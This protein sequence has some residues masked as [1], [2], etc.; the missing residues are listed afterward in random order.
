MAAISFKAMGPGEGLRPQVEPQLVEYGE[1]KAIKDAGNLIPGQWYRIT[2]YVT[3]TMQ[4]DTQSAGHQFDILV[5]ATG[6]TTLCEKA[7]AVQHEG[8]EYFADS[9]L[10]AWE[11]R[12]TLENVQWSAVKGITVWEEDNWPLTSAGTVTI[13]NTEYMLWKAGQ[14]LYDDSGAEWFVSEDAEAGT[15]LYEYDPETG[16]IVE[17]GWSVEIVKSRSVDEDGVGTILWMKDEFGNE[18]PYDFKNIQFKRWAVTDSVSGRQGLN[19][20]YLGVYRFTPA[21]ITISDETDF[22]WAY[23][24]SSDAEGGD[25]ED[26]SLGGNHIIENVILSHPDGIIPDNV[27]F[28]SYNDGNSIGICS[29]HNS[30]AGNCRSN[31]IGSYFRMNVAG[32]TL[33]HNHFGN[34]VYGNSFGNSFSR[35]TVGD[36]MSVM[37]FSHQCSN[38]II[39]NAVGYSSWGYNCSYNTIGNKVEHA[40]IGNNVIYA[41]VLNKTSGTQPSP[42]TLNFASGVEYSQVACLDSSKHLVIYVPGDVGGGG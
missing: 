12:Y 34:D 18:C 26:F 38:N 37:S 40:N 39:G 4:E 27:F 32:N 2:D 19:G 14:D 31:T 3:T 17:D 36:D 41:Q 1:L 16:E 10:E 21:D 13:D 25:Q 9:K 35:N 5:M 30:F 7:F 33:F 20:L 28:G 6:K 24:F 15:M 8:D 23:T 29:E 11:L 22:I 42:L